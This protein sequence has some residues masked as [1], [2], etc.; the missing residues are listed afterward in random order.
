M[1]NPLFFVHKLWL[2]KLMRCFYWSVV[3][4]DRN[5]IEHCARSGP[6]RLTKTYNKECNGLN[7]H[8]N[9]ITNL[10]TMVTLI[11]LWLVIL[12]NFKTQSNKLKTKSNISIELFE[13]HQKCKMP[14][15][16]STRKALPKERILDG[17]EVQ[18]LVPIHRG[19]S[20]FDAN[21]L[22]LTRW[23]CYFCQIE[24]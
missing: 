14:G 3:Q 11:I 10:I 7:N 5:A 13:L 16:V 23:W 6:E 20:L 2:N 4:N 12:Q 1:H 19:F 15:Y 17:R 22:A 21:G 8:S 9:L 18:S 24:L